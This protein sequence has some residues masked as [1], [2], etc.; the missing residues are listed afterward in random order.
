MFSNKRFIH[1]VKMSSLYHII[2]SRVVYMRYDRQALKQTN[3]M[4][5]ILLRIAQAGPKIMVYEKKLCHKISK[6]G[7]THT[8]I[9]VIHVT[10]VTSYIH[11]PHTTMPL[12]ETMVMKSNIALSTVYSCILST[13][14][15]PF[16]FFET[17]LVMVNLV[18]PNFI[19]ESSICW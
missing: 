7:L 5:L 11:V 19:I 8:F 4:A 14:T 12:L 6:I 2:I 10:I 9:H 15:T 1:I 13:I 18:I 16:L 17:N 3:V